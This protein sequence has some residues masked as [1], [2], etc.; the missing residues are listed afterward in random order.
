MMFIKKKPYSMAQLRSEGQG[1][2]IVVCLIVFVV[3]LPVK[4]RA[5]FTLDDE[6]KVGKELYE[7][8]ESDN[9][10][11]RDER[12]NAFMNR[13]GAR[14][15][16]QVDN[17][18]FD[19]KFS[20]IRSSA[21]NAFATPGGYVYVNQ[22]LITLAEN[23]G[24]LASVLAH[25]IAHIS[26]R[27]IAENV[28]R[29]KIVSL[30]A[31]AAILAGAL[32]GGSSDVSAAVAGFSMATATTLSLQY[33]R[34]QEESADRMGIAT[35]VQAGYS[36]GEMLDFMKIMRRYEYYSK[37]IP[38]YFLT[39]PGTDERMRYIDALLQTNYPG[40]GKQNIVGNLKRM[41][42]ML[43]LNGITPDTEN[44][45]QFQRLINENPENVDA[46]YGLAVTQEK[47][48]MTNVA[49]ESFH[50][51]LAFAPDDADILRDL[52]NTFFKL[53]RFSEAETELKRSL[54]FLPN[55][56][57]ALI[58]LGRTFEAQGNLDGAIDQ[59]KQIEQ[60]HPDYQE[61]LYSL[62][63]AYGKAGQ[64]GESH[65]YFGLHFK[66]KGKPDSALFHFKAAAK[67]FSPDS[68]R[69]REIVKEIAGLSSPQKG[70]PPAAA[71]GKKRYAIPYF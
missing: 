19:F 48:G 5:D 14:L 15:L 9:L 3:F 31:L 67:Y 46:L 54:R 50:K 45:Q 13:I 68:S 60:K 62:A 51:A 29:S 18:S 30:S 32:L 59:Y 70:Q 16:E 21:I 61:L 47:L 24:Q 65:Y 35:L 53:G 43:M 66:K 55:D 40:K 27:H 34:Q 12:V 39:H 57:E 20:I 36:G 71:Q 28:A 42:T 58:T 25:E 10:L 37:S 49:L 1:I 11:L 22:G 17:P 69:G 33:S 64:A 38:S 4:A 26:G 56:P 44:L 7:K 52:G 41:Q 63:M 23:E 2:A 6:K 8:L